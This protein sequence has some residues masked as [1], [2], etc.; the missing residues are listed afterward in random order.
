MD[1]ADGVWPWR[2]VNA[3]ARS[4]VDTFAG[5]DTVVCNQSHFPLRLQEE[6]PQRLTL[7]QP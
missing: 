6:M 3:T 1:S 5:M 4:T 2:T 7:T